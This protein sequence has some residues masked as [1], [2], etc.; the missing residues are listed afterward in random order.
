MSK[1]WYFLNYILIKLIII[2]RLLSCLCTGRELSDIPVEHLLFYLKGLFHYSCIITLECNCRCGC[3]YLCIILILYCIIL[4][5][6]SLAIC[7][8]C[9]GYRL[10]CL[11]VIIATIICKGYILNLCYCLAIIRISTFL[12][13]SVTYQNLTSVSCSTCCCLQIPIICKFMSKCWYIFCNI[14]TCQLIP[15]SLQSLFCTCWCSN[16]LPC[17]IANTSKLHIL[18]IT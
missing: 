4:W 11:A 16:Y 5:I 12:R 3:S 8:C 9:C 2:S 18:L 7:I 14:F 6:N 15:C 13:T 1:R 10:L 17:N